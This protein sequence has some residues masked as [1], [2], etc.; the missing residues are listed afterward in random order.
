MSGSWVRVP[1]D[2]PYWLADFTVGQF[3]LLYRQNMTFWSLLNAGFFRYCH[4]R[5]Q[6]VLAGS[7]TPTRPPASPISGDRRP[8]F[9]FWRKNRCRSMENFPAGF[10]RF[11]R[12]SDKRSKRIKISIAHRHSQPGIWHWLHCRMPVFSRLLSSLPGWKQTSS[13]VDRL[14]FIRKLQ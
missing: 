14:N 3:L 11:C 1:D 9:G 10:C 8:F 5:F 7:S 4:G 6:P 13:L 12:F 2:V